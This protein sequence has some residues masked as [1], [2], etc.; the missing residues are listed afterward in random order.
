MESRVPGAE[1]PSVS[2]VIPGRNVSSTLDECLSAVAPLLE[3]RQLRE[4]IFVDDGSED[5][6][7]EIASTYPV[8]TLESGGGGRGA[9][10]NLG[11][12]AASGDLIWFID[13]DCVSEPG[14]LAVLLQHVIDPDVVA[15]GG[16]Y[17]NMR[18]DSLLACLIHE[19]IVARHA[20][21]PRRVDFLATFNALYRRS[22]L[23]S[24]DGFD[25]SL[26]RAQDADLAYRVRQTVGPLEFDA[27]S[28]VK[29]F[30]ATKLFPYLRA[31]RSQGFW[32]MLLYARH[33]SAAR[34]DSYS[35]WTDHLQPPVALLATLSAPFLLLPEVAP[36]AGLPLLVLAVLQVPMTL[37]ILRRTKQLRYVAYAPMSMIRAF[38]R[39]L[40]LAGGT[41]A[42]LAGTLRGGKERG[43]PG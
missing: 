35:D 38:A 17:G 39:G 34:G 9:A 25:E 31:Q 29:H 36:W 10:R 11:W 33:P 21:M 12:R 14:A 18:P 4:I 42:A 7:R 28:R 16:S 13:A 43:A 2:L 19:E 32:R 3:E 22:A 15:V 8:T 23:E 41:L 27:N 5:S 37:R 1:A 26:L 20:R 24:V 6:T 30:H 40:G